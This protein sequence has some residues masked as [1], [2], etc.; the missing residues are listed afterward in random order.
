MSTLIRCDPNKIWIDLVCFT[1]NYIYPT[2][3]LKT[4]LKAKQK[5]SDSSDAAEPLE[6]KTTSRCHGSAFAKLCPVDH[7]TV[8]R[9]PR[10]VAT[11]VRHC[12]VYTRHMI[13]ISCIL[14]SN[15]SSRST[16]KEVVHLQLS[17]FWL[18]TALGDPQ[19]R[20]SKTEENGCEQQRHWTGEE[21]HMLPSKHR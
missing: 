12:H 9:P 19:L 2:I 13:L 20:R 10:D 8:L 11:T 15:R 4:V 1:I 7:F 17:G 6:L 21:C 18:R 5:P 14:Y 3:D 16:S